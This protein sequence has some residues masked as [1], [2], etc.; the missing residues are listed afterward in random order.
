MKKLTLDL[1]S[2]EVETFDAD[3]RTGARGTVLARTGDGCGSIA[4][5]CDTEDVCCYAQSVGGPCGTSALCDD[6]SVC[7]GTRC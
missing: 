3:E 1:D 4:S 5:G 7:Y 2:L 6:L